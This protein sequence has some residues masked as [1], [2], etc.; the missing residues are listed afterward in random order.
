MFKPN[1]TL[2]STLLQNLT[3]IER[4]YGRLESLRLPKKLQL[5]L[6][7]DNLIQ[8]AYISNSIEGNSLS[9]PEVTNLLLDERVPVNRDEKEVRNYFDILRNLSQD[10]KKSLNLEYLLSVHQQL[11][12][13]VNNDIAGTIRNKR[14]VVGKRRQVN[15]KLILHVKHEPPYHSAV[16]IIIAL[17]QLFSWLEDTA[18]VPTILTAGIFHHEFVYLHPFIDGNGRTCR[19]LTALILLQHNYEIN[20]YFVLDDWYDVNRKEYSD[21]LHT[22]DSGDKTTWLEYFTAGVR[23]SLQSA[24]TKA[25][26]AIQHVNVAQRLSNKEQ[27][28]YALL[29]QRQQLTASDIEREFHVSRQYAHRLLSALVQK[30]YAAE[31]GETKGRYYVLL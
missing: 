13:G 29:Q 21:S 14:I 31:R 6:E 1:Y 19:L 15:G 28:A 16:K 3:K 2:T 9:L 11:L 20:K 7:R 18:N 24:L 4:L 23:Y 10:V 30:G 27:V 5:N 12:V 25:E 22:A 8:S 17:Q 26:Q